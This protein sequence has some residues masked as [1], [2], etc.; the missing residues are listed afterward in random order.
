MHTVLIYSMHVIAENTTS[1]PTLDIPG[2]WRASDLAPQWATTPSGFQALDQVLPGGG[3]PLAHLTSVQCPRP[4][5]EWRLLGTALQNASR[6]G[7]VLLL[8][9]PHRPHLGA[10]VA[11]GFQMPNLWWLQTPMVHDLV[12]ALERGLRC[13]HLAALVF[14]PSVHWPRAAWQRL[15]RACTQAVA[16]PP[17][18]VF[19]VCPEGITLQQTRAPLQLSVTSLGALGLQVAVTKRPGPPLAHPLVLHAPLAVWPSWP[20]WSAPTGQ[21]PPHTPTAR[22]HVVDRFDTHTAR[23][24]SAA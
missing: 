14:W 7:V 17:P 1:S 18:L 16:N 2:V 4:G 20:A 21:H 22:H 19:A 10:L 13:E 8:T 24:T 15:Q 9:P 23:T 5:L 3:W 12:W 11:M 6:R